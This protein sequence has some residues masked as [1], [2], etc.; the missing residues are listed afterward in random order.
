MGAWWESG[1]LLGTEEAGMVSAVAELTACKCK[2]EQVWDTQRGWAC[3][4]VILVS[5][6]PGKSEISLGTLYTQERGWNPVV[7]NPDGKV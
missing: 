2:E 6:S 7:G 3:L 4:Q 5:M 1:P